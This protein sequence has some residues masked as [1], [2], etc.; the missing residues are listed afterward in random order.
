[1]GYNGRNLL[2]FEWVSPE[3][4]IIRVGSFDASGKWFSADGPGPSMK[5][6][7]RGYFGYDGGFGVFTK[8]AVKLY[9]WPGPAEIP[10]EYHG[11]DLVAKVPQNFHSYKLIVKD[12]DTARDAFVLLSE[13][14]ICYFM[15]KT[16]YPRVFMRASGPA[17]VK[18]IQRKSLYNAL[19]ATKQYIQ[20]IH[21]GGCPIFRPRH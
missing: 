1:M 14:D 16:S 2:G 10:T 17:Y 9:H 4:E 6:I 8:A 18:A 20:I 7:A 21:G 11:Y 12:W 13:A 15:H 5:G 19:A 3:G